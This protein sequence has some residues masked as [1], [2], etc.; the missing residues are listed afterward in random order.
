MCVVGVPGSSDLVANRFAVGILADNSGE[1]AWVGL[2]KVL[3]VFG[4]QDEG[5]VLG[6][7]GVAGSSVEAGVTGVDRCAHL[8][9]DF[10]L[11]VYAEANCNSIRLI[12]IERSIGGDAEACG[13]YR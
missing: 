12:L 10:A 7:E 5:Y 8:A 2:V 13:W 3:K 4:G 9:N 1:D 6:R 11:K